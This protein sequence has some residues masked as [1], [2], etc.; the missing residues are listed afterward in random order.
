MERTLAKLAAGEHVTIIAL[1]DS[2]TE[3][4]FHTR[5]RMN[6]VGLLREAIFEAYGNGV[7]TFINSGVCGA[8]ADSSLPRL[9]RDVLRFDPDLVV[10]ALGMN[11]A[12]RGEA[13]LPAFV[14]TLRTIAKRIREHNGA[15]ILLRTSNPVVA[16]HGVPLP[17]GAAPGK[18]YETEAR[19]LRKYAE[20]TVRLAEELGCPVADHHR[21]WSEQTFRVKHAVADPTGLWPRMGDSI[22]PGWGGHLAFFRELAPFFR[23]PRFFPWEEAEAGAE[24]G[25]S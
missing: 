12:G 24:G 11:D 3:V 21:L 1:G 2:N 22:H 16:G 6:W 23:V 9:E 8:T 14:E 5:G 17:E 25:M 7:C 4:T 20:A 19:P 10:I 15:E 18:P 13:G